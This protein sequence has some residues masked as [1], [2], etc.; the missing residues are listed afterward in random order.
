M[1]NFPG[2]LGIAI[3]SP[4]NP[5]ELWDVAPLVA[6]L[7]GVAEIMMGSILRGG[8]EFAWYRIPSIQA[9]RG[10]LIQPKPC[11]QLGESY[12]RYQWKKREENPLG[13]TCRPREARCRHVNPLITLLVSRS[14]YEINSFFKGV[15]REPACQGK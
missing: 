8:G 9:G 13:S 6:G 14:D 5:C 7:Q 12:E 11:G 10:Q 2:G 1:R 4:R 3:S 15:K